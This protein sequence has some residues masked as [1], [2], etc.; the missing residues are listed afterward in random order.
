LITNLEQTTAETKELRCYQQQQQKNN[1]SKAIDKDN[2]FE[3]NTLTYH[4]K[5]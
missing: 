1:F 5:G 4:E 3:M 2:N